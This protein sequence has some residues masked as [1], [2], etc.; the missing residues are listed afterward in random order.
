[1]ILSA[2]TLVNFIIDNRT[3]IERIDIVFKYYNVFKRYSID[4]LYCNSGSVISLIFDEN[5]RKASGEVKWFW[6][7]GEDK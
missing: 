7:S 6:P 2:R 3:R 5:I 1:M 4:F